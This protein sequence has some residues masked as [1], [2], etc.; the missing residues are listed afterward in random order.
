M[1][2]ASRKHRYKYF[3]A[4]GKGRACFDEKREGICKVADYT[5]SDAKE[6]VPEDISGGKVA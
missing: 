3:G 4:A 2:C 5:I 6:L 1:G